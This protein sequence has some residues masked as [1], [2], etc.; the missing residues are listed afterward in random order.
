MKSIILDQSN[1][2]SKSDHWDSCICLQTMK[3]RLWNINVCTETY[4][5]NICFH[6]QIYRSRNESFVQK[7]VHYNPPPPKVMSAEI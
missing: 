2:L 6:K 5:M 4:L 3:M 1:N 7:F